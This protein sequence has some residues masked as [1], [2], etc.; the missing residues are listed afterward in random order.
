MMFCFTKLNMTYTLSVCFVVWFN[1][2]FSFQSLEVLVLSNLW[3]R[4]FS[5]LNIF[6]ALLWD[7]LE[8]MI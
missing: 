4:Q 6:S 3:I 5:M 8:Q 2:L 1:L 7:D